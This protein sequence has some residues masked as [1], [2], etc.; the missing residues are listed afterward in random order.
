MNNFVQKIDPIMIMN[1]FK[2]FTDPEII[3]RVD[4]GLIE[5][6]KKQKEFEA[7]LKKEK[8][9]ENALE[10]FIDFINSSLAPKKEPLKEETEINPGDEKDSK[11]ETIQQ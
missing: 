11:E 3:N 4:E 5:A 2:Q 6:T 10:Q 9:Q 7:G 1:G 8:Q